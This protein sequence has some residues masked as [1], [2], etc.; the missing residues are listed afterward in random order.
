M[1]VRIALAAGLALLAIALL[2]TLS[3]A[4][5]EVIRSNQP[6]AES[7][8][9]HI[10]GI[11]A[12][13]ARVCQEDELVP[14][15]TSAIDLSARTDTM[16]PALT[17]RV[18]SGGRVISEGSR[19]AG[20]RGPG[21]TV[22]VATIA[23]TVP[24]A[25]VCFTTGTLLEM[26]GMRGEKTARAVGLI[27]D[28]RRVAGRMK[29]RYL[30]R[31][32]GSWFS[33][34]RSVARRMGLGHAPGGAWGALL[35]AL[36]M[37]A[38][39]VLTA[40][41]LLRELAGDGLGALPGRWGALPTPALVCMAV[42]FLSAASWS[43]ISP[44]FQVN[45]EEAHFAYV[46]QLAEARQLPHA[47]LTQ[48]FSIEEETAMRDLHFN[49]LRL[50]G[51]S[52]TI[53]A[54]NQQA[55]LTRELNAD[56]A[57]RG[58]GN[59]GVAA[60]E[61]PLYYALE[62][63]PYAA[64]WWGS[65]L[66]RMELMRLFSALLGAGSALLVYLFLRELLPG[67][68]WL[69]AVGGLA[70]A[71]APLLGTM[72]GAINPDALL[73]TVAA[74]CFYLLARGFRRGLT[75]RLAVAIGAVIALGLLTKLNFIGLAP[76]ALL[77]LLLLSA[78]AARSAGVAVYRRLALVLLVLAAPIAAYA[79]LA[80]VRDPVGLERLWSTIPTPFP[81]RPG[82]VGELSYVWQAYLPPL[83]GMSRIFPGVSVWR[84]VWFPELLG[85]YGW[86]DI[87]FSDRV[88][89]L[90][91]IPALGIAALCARALIVSRGALRARVAEIAVYAT[92]AA[93]LLVVIAISSYEVYPGGAMEY[94]LGRYMLPLLALAAAGVALAARG[95]GRRWGAVAGTLM[96]LLIL[97]HDVF[98]QLLVIARYYG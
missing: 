15:G 56:P 86:D 30:R 48:L 33:T 87:Y 27:S 16:G 34:A 68:R 78:R 43:L 77:G 60:S 96:V 84:E 41:L 95:V 32:P 80:V 75:R 58:T 40:W 66:A 61:P 81:R 9:P 8:E 72:S 36:A 97:A 54:R 76:G 50:D 21:L 10:A 24:H 38:A 4:P 57:R 67:A 63:V 31:N 29:I 3:R 93:G 94:R 35:P 47:S 39:A 88:N 17:V 44:L 69:W 52:H 20:W 7:I 5:L 42:A 25:T 2:A 89:E 62:T 22:R 53:G 6:A 51:I 13:K 71:L 91:L 82:S 11:A 90:A 98:S 73:A 26:L 18:L 46:Q 85:Y 19:A 55:R 92:M 70:A 28:G 49:D 14:A 59:A 65:I 64:G 1:R 23:H 83:P 12:G 45:D 79:V 37:I 74:A